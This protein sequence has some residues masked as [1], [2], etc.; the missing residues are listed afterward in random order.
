MSKSETVPERYLPVFCQELYQLYRAGITPADGIALLREDEDDPQ[1]SRWLDVLIDHINE[2]LTLAEALRSSK[3]FPQ[4]MTD[5]IALAENTGR[6]EET[7]LALER[8]Y[9]RKIR[10]KSDIR[11]AITVPVVL[12]VVMIA[13]VVLL[14]TQVLPVFDRVFAQL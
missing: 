11:S 12:L 1:V 7:L 8:H 4:Y 10:L 13:V 9:V 6:L 5:M 3:V 2:G 14:I